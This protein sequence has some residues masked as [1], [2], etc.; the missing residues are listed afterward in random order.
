MAD[1]AVSRTAFLTPTHGLLNLMRLAA[2]HLVVGLWAWLGLDYLEWPWFVGLGAMLCLAHQRE[3]NDW[4]HEAV[5]WNLHPNRGVNELFGNLFASFWFGM[6]LA[7][8]RRAH[9]LHHKTQAF[10]VPEDPDTGSLRIASRKDLIW[11][12]LRD[13]SGIG[14][15]Y[16]YAGYVLRR[17]HGLSAKSFQPAEA[18]WVMSAVVAGHLILFSVLLW[19]GRWQIYV[20]YYA[21]LVTL[22]RFSHRIRI[23]GQHLSIDEN[24]YGS[25]DNSAVSR[26]VV[27]NLIDKLIFATDVMLYHYEHHKRPE[28]PYRAL[29]AICERKP[30]QNRYMES[31]WPTLRSIWTLSR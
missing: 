3:M 4:A 12:M 15:L 8:L 22:Y 9:L 14:A 1:F 21:T 29:R 10:F 20:L 30:D 25:C 11:G 13:L 7:S 19:V 28:L 6:P 17:K 24:G 16:H 23:Y 27:G 31:R 18:R 5:H 2:W 26:T